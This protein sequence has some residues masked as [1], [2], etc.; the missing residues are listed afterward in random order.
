LRLQPTRKRNFD[1]AGRC[2]PGIVFG[3]VDLWR[4]CGRP[5]QFEAHR[6][7]SLI[8][9]GFVNRCGFAY[10][11]YWPSAEFSGV[12][13]YYTPYPETAY[14]FMSERG[15]PVTAATFRKMLARAVDAAKLRSADDLFKIDLMV[16]WRRRGLRAFGADKNADVIAAAPAAP[17]P[18]VD[19]PAG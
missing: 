18:A 19:N 8:L 6:R 9:L 13:V 1:I 14:V 3:K 4:F 7:V 5:G 12:R 16:R 17:P 15:A 11:T 2:P 10:G